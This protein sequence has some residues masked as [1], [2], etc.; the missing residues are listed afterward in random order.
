MHG[1]AT[2]SGA[3]RGNRNAHKHGWYSAETRAALRELGAA[4]RRMSEA[5]DD[6]EN[7]TD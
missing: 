3:P 6:V 5:L 1:G 7:G 2:G 4:I